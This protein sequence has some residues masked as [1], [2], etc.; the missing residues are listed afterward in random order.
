MQSMREHWGT[1][2]DH[3]GLTASLPRQ[4]IDFRSKLQAGGMLEISH[5][6][7][8]W[9]MSTWARLL[10]RLSLSDPLECEPCRVLV[11]SFL[12]LP[13]LGIAYDTQYQIRSSTLPLLIKVLRAMGPFMLGGFPNTQWC[14]YWSL[15]Y[16]MI[17][18]SSDTLNSFTRRARGAR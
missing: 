8:P 17:S 9:K 1:Y 7:T 3:Y 10:C 14:P 4:A 6:I 18:S 12:P 13:F 11:Q 16:D 5:L 15:C 2:R